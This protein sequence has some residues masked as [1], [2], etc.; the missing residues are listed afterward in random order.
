MFVEDALNIKVG[1]PVVQQLDDIASCRLNK[2]IKGLLLEKG[3]CAD[4]L[5]FSTYQLTCI[6]QHGEFHHTV[7]TCTKDL[8]CV[9]VCSANLALYT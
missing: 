9:D 3:T 6:Y 8:Q 5:I 4:V 1:L 7:S 2:E